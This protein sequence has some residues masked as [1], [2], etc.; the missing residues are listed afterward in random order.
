MI[1]SASTLFWANI[2][3]PRKR[4]KEFRRNELLES[5]LQDLNS[6]LSS[7]ESSLADRYVDKQMEFPLILVM[8]GLRSG[9]TLFMQWLANSGLV[10][11]PTNMLSR[12]YRAPIIGA[13]IQLMLTAPRFEFRGE[14]N[15]L[16]GQTGYASENGKTRGALEPNEF[17]Y[18]WRRFLSDPTVDVWSDQ[19]LKD[20]MDVSLM[21]AELQGIADVFRLPFAAKGMM[22]NYNIRFLNSVFEK[23]LFVWLNRDPATNVTSILSARERQFGSTS[24]WYSFK[25]PEYA[26]LKNLPAMDQAVGQYYYN[27]KAIAEGLEDVIESRKMCVQYEDFCADPGA[28][29]NELTGKMGLSERTY[30]GPQSF[31][32]SRVADEQLAKT[33]CHKLNDYS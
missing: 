23:V 26:E 21:R 32:I 3:L 27:N 9:T 17:W 22:F 19:E 13:K 4:T 16:L 11:Y 24:E 10:A 18:F 28:F 5:L 31:D 14:L 25:I 7:A 20:S 29:Y 8:G 2:L 1:C 33:I 12:F 30:S 15:E 6:D